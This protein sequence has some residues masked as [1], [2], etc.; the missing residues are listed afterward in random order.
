MEVS[1]KL[2]GTCER[3]QQE[4]DQLRQ[5]GQ[6]S[7][8]VM[9]TS[10]QIDTMHPAMHRPNHIVSHILYLVAMRSNTKPCSKDLG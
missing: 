6:R 2:Q 8:A 5:G 4:N 1:K 10:H 9:P 7:R 3:L